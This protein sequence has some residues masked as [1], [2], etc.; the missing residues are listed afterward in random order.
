MK[1]HWINK[2]T[3]T[4]IDLLFWIFLSTCKSSAVTVLAFNEVGGEPEEAYYERTMTSRPEVNSAFVS[5]SPM[6]DIQTSE[7]SISFS[8]P[9]DLF[10]SPDDPFD[11]SNEG[12]Q[13]VSEYQVIV[14]QGGQPSAIPRQVPKEGST[15]NAK[16]RQFPSSCQTT[17]KRSR[18]SSS[19]PS[20]SVVLGTGEGCDDVSKDYCDRKLEEDSEY[21]VTIRGFSSEETFTDFFVGTFSTD[22]NVSYKCNINK[23]LYRFYRFQGIGMEILIAIVAGVVLVLAVVVVIV[24]IVLLRKTSCKPKTEPTVNSTPSRASTTL[25]AQIRKPIKFNKFRDEFNRLSAN[26][27]FAAEFEDITARLKDRKFA[28]N[29]TENPGCRNSR[30]HAKS[31]SGEP[32]GSLD[33]PCPDMDS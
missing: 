8:L 30:W 12:I 5:A 20:W 24:L 27:N 4:N 32:S 3:K 19:D 2:K 22:S 7:S 21:T 16:P 9:C 18:R 11:S 31:R 29:S 25:S 17:S 6:S 1:K 26:D 28:K 13:S 14:T 15:Y 33:A 10:N 23:F